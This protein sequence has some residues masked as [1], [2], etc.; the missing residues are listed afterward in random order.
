M[1]RFKVH[2]QPVGKELEKR[3]DVIAAAIRLGGTIRNLPELELCYAPP[4]SVAKDP[5]NILGYIACNVADNVYD[6]VH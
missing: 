4:F 5:V 2:R 3:I 1:A 6:M